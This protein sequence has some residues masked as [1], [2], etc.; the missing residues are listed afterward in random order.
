MCPK[1][2]VVSTRSSPCIKF[3]VDVI[4]FCV[5]SCILPSCTRRERRARL[6]VAVAVVCWRWRW[7]GTAGAA[8]AQA[9]PQPQGTKKWPAGIWTWHMGARQPP[10]TSPAAQ[11]PAA[12]RVLNELYIY[13]CCYRYLLFALHPVHVCM[14]VVCVSCPASY[15]RCRAGSC[16]RRGRGCMFVAVCVARIR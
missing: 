14:C 3:C 16:W 10:A 8:A 2:S 12:R 11:Q 4:T 7:R 5:P 15:V 9:P 13:V 6:P 1:V